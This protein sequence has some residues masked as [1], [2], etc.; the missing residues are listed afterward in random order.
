MNEIIKNI[1]QRRSTR[2]FK[3]EQVG[4]DKIKLIMDCAV[5]APSARNEQNWHFTVIQKASLI[6]EINADIKGAL[7][8]E[9]VKK[10]EARYNGKSNFSLFYDAPT[11]IIV[12]GDEGEWSVMNCAY[13][14]QNILLAAESLGLNSCIIGFAAKL[15]K[16]TNGD[17]YSNIFG[18]PAGYKSQYAISLGYKAIDMPPVKREAGKITIIK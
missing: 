15:F 2:G 9:A 8:A 13:A 10:M 18:L 16:G 11:V 14:T 1:M 6:N 5:N 12:S 7:D 17:K 3:K 4:D